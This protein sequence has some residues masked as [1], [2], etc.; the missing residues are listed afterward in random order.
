M[1]KDMNKMKKDV[2]VKFNEIKN[3]LKDANSKLI[4][5]EKRL[6]AVG[7]SFT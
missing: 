7:L 3:E 6:Y 5:L 1:K 2:D 4:D